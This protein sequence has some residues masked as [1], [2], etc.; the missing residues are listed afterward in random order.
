M[1]VASHPGAVFSRFTSTNTA[2]PGTDARKATGALQMVLLFR[3]VSRSLASDVQ[4]SFFPPTNTESLVWCA[5]CL[6]K[7]VLHVSAASLQSEC[8]A[9]ALR[10]S[11][12]PGFTHT[13]SLAQGA[14]VN[15][16]R[17]SCRCS[18]QRGHFQ[19]DALAGHGHI[20]A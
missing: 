18:T 16:G 12:L 19:H 13:V 10:P 9:R 5:T 2:P 15:D 17:N 4:A 11:L 20:C 3:L 7:L 14:D 1:F 6:R 8:I